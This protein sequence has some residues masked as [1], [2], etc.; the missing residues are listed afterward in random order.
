MKTAQTKKAPRNDPCRITTIT[1]VL[2][3]TGLFFAF[4]IY[5]W[6]HVSDWVVSMIKI[7]TTYIILNEEARRALGC[8]SNQSSEACDVVQYPQQKPW[9]HTHVEEKVIS[10]T[11]THT[12][13]HA[14]PAQT[15][16]T[17]RQTSSI[18]THTHIHSTHN[19]RIN[20]WICKSDCVVSVCVC[21]C[22][23]DV[24]IY[25]YIY[26]YMYIYLYIYIPLLTWNQFMN[27]YEWL[28]RVCVSLQKS[29]DAAH[30][31]P[32]KS[33]TSLTKEP[34]IPNKRAVWCYPKEPFQTKP[35]QIQ[36]AARKS[37][38]AALPKRKRAICS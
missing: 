36:I 31:K 21:V 15:H 18:H 24:Y 35:Q 28:C 3:D 22:L 8:T 25:I 13:I 6:I 2:R 33:P 16:T 12:N 19:K 29:R 20:V 30:P 4:G 17:Y 11:N 1:R 23:G 38:D 32:K 34:C 27:L 14:L 10:H 26:I 5:A 37:W 7:D 9:A